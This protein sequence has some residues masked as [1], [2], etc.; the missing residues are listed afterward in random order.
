MKFRLLP[1]NDNKKLAAVAY[2]QTVLVGNYG[3]VSLTAAPALQL[4][5]L[6]RTSDT[7]LAF[8]ATAGDKTVNLQP[9]YD[10]QGFNYVTYWS[11]QG[12]LPA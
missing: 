2:G 3:T 11:L 12:S 7:A 9:Y 1:A 8:S 6:K 5:S 4:G 10:G